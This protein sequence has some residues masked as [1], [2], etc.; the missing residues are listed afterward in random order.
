MSYPEPRGRKLSGIIRIGAFIVVFSIFLLTA[1]VALG[2]TFSA[3]NGPAAKLASSPVNW[4]GLYLFVKSATA[5]IFALLGMLVLI[6]VVGALIAA[7][8]RLGSPEKGGEY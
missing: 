1:F 3:F 7:T 5:N 2:A 8:F 6:A 4:H